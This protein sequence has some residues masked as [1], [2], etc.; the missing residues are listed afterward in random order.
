M[1]YKETLN[2]L[3]PSFQQVG[4][5]GYKPGLE[6]SVAL[7]TLLK[8]PH[9]H[10]RTIHV[11]GTNGKGSVSHLLAAALRNS[12]YKVGLYTSPHVC[13]FCERIRVNGKKISK[14]FVVDFVESNKPL[15][16]SIEPSFF[17]ITTALAFEYFRHK[18]VDLAVIE[19][20]LGGR[21]DSTNIMNPLLSIITNISLD[22]TQYLGNTLVQIAHE[23]AGIIKPNIPVV[24]G[25][26]GKNDEVRRVFI[27]KAMS[28]SSPV[29]F[30]EKENVLVSTK[31][32][33][34]GEFEF[35]SVDFGVFTGELKGLVQKQNAR[36][37]LM[38]LRLLK[39][40]RVK[41]PVKAVKNAFE[42]V[43]GLTGLMGR[44]QTI[45]NNPLIIC[46]TGHNI[47]A[48]VVLSKQI[49]QEATKHQTLRMVVGMVSDKEIEPVLSTMPSNAVYYFT[50]ASVCRA[51]PAQ[52]FAEK[53]GQ[54]NLRG[55]H[56]DTVKKAV[57][58]AISDSSPND[59]IFIGGSTFVVGDALYFLQYINNKIL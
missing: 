35:Q 51:M 12:K 1:T 31:K 49:R 59:M 39:N 23:K 21:F 15:I 52:Q 44:W 34:T 20:G 47:G 27:E 55:Q 26:T 25:E 5:A 24:I 29:Y 38:A 13:D 45:Q 8:H 17:E 28:V 43:T 57:R 50:Q 41:I 48:W 2:F 4:A 10:Y 42:H 56:Y 37:V 3:S 16:Q 7:D 58:Q 54:F 46:D 11:A 32:L 18:K 22:H 9:Q 30:A 33:K 6:R 36:T 53:A 14:R 19:V 40:M